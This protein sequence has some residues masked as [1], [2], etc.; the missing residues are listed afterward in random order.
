M[1]PRIEIIEEK[2][3]MGMFDSMSLVENK[4]FQLFSTFMPRRKKITDAINT[5][6]FD[7]KV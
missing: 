2:K 1:Q 6:V 5:D 3:L 7:L 4:T